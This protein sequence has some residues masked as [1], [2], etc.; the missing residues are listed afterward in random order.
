MPLYYFFDARSY[1]I[2]A[3]MIFLGASVRMAGFLPDAVIALFYCGLGAA[4]IIAGIY[5]I[6]S[7]VSVC[8]E[9]QL[10]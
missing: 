5:L 2:M 4:L 9:L 3:V 7:Y 1:I 10:R 8:D 6:V